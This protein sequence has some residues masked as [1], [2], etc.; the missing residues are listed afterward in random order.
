MVTHYINMIIIEVEKLL[1]ETSRERAN[2]SEVY[3]NIHLTVTLFGDVWFFFSRGLESRM[4][5]T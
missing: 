2:H 4:L 3:Y 1:Y 5:D